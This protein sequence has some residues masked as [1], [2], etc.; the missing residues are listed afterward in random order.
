MKTRGTTPLITSAD[1]R[2]GLSLVEVLLAVVILSIGITVLVDAASRCLAVVR[3]SRNYETVRHLLARVEVE[4]PLQLEDE[5]KEGSENGDFKGGPWDYT[6][7]REIVIIGEEEDRLFE[8]RT[9][10]FKAGTQPGSSEEIVTW[11]Y[12]P[13]K[14]GETGSET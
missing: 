5:I 8:V 13:K 11:M 9:R 10:V 14:G 6:W 1:S 12:I 7:T 4:N 3:Q 2:A